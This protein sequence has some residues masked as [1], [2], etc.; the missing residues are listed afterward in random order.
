MNDDDGDEIELPLPFTNQNYRCNVRVTNFRPSS[1][2]DF[3]RGRKKID[4]DVLSDNGESPGSSDSEGYDDSMTANVTADLKWEWRFWLELED[5]TCENAERVWV[6]LD[7]QSAEL[8]TSLDAC[9]LR[10]NP[11]ILGKLRQKMFILWGNLEEEKSSHRSQTPRSGDD[12]RLDSSDD[13]TV[14]MKISNQPFP[15]C[16]KQYGIK[17]LEQDAGKATAGNNLRWE[18]MF[19]M[20]G[21]KVSGA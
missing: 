11:E 4:F 8:L 12:V 15:C 17:V 3:T 1:L 7:N 13:E 16:I 20:Y 2:E 21:T 5:A 10:R 14:G 19:G 9:D 6:V 18:R